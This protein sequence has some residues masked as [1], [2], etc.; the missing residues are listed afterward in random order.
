MLFLVR[1]LTALDGTRGRRG[2]PHAE[3]AVRLEALLI[4]SLILTGLTVVVATEP[5]TV[6]SASR[7][8]EVETTPGA[9][10]AVPQIAS[11]GRPAVAGVA[12]SRPTAKAPVATRLPAPVA[13]TATSKRWLPTGTGMWTYLWRNTEGGNTL[14]V[15]RRAEAMGLSHLYVRTGTR[16]AGFNGGPVLDSLLPATRGTDIKVIAWDFPI[17]NN[18]VA[19]A[20][21]LAKA[22]WHRAPGKGTPMVAA[23]APDIETASE[24]TQLSPGKVDLYYRELRKRLPKHV[25]ILATV[26]WPSEHRVGKYP[27]AVTAKHADALVPMAYWINR[28]PTTVTRQSMQ[29]LKQFGKPIMP[30]G[31]A[32]DPRIDVPS[33]KLA[34][35]SRAQVDAFFA[36]A[37]KYGAPSAS[38]WVWNTANGN[39]WASIKKAGPMFD[40]SRPVAPKPPSKP[41]KPPKPATP[42]VTPP[43]AV[44]KPRPPR[45]AQRAE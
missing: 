16:K 29:R 27:F 36:T 44:R 25:A 15:V 6:P 10:Q 39:H 17:L 23:V 24:G 9:A 20:R 28:D 31:Q 18:P 43:D 5:A 1:A 19:D 35:P 22:A 21:R 42:P 12:T 37:K 34:A 33:L 45:Q 30:A 4:A 8:G 41:P 11:L 13:A 32:Y 14:A 2:M 7:T 38:L 3:L 26:P 40:P